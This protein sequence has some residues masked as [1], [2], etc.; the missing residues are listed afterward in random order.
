MEPALSDVMDTCSS[1]RPRRVLES[2]AVAHALAAAL[3]ERCWLLTDGSC[4][5]ACPG[6]TLPWMNSETVFAAGSSRSPIW[7]PTSSSTTHTSC[8]RGDQSSVITVKAPLQ[9]QRTR[10]HGAVYLL[11]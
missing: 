8:A 7:D 9:H 11:I 5:A 4:G 1:A 6:R 3:L 10:Q 2:L